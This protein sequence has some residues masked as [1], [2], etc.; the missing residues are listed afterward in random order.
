MLAHAGTCTHMPAQARACTGRAWGVHGCTGMPRA[1]TGVHGACT[2]RARACTGRAWGV[3]GC[4]GV[5]GACTG[6]HRPFLASQFGLP[7]A[8][9]LSQC[10]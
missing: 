6:M 3:H 10:V 7:F 4:T 1:C 9:R 5:H 8:M 2:G